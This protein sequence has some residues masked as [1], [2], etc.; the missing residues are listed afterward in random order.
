MRCR[1]GEAFVIRTA[2]HESTRYTPYYVNFEGEIVMMDGENERM[3]R[4][5]EVREMSRSDQET[6]NEEEAEREPELVGE[7]EQVHA[8][9]REMLDQAYARAKSQYDRRR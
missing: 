1:P 4:E 8:K 3:R 6:A 9:V 2:K 5:R 7:L